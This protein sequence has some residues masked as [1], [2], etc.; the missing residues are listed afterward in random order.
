MVLLKWIARDSILQW[1]NDFY[2]GRLV[3]KFGIEVIRAKTK[4]IKTIGARHYYINEL[5]Q[6]INTSA[7]EGRVT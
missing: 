7:I 2:K 6:G 5:C 1:N 4:V 3:E